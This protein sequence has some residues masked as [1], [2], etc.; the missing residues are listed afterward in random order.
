MLG[1]TLWHTA[2]GRHKR[3][4]F[5]DLV[6]VL[7]YTRFLCWKLC[8]GWNANY[9]PSERITSAHCQAKNRVA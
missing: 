2:A 8:C 5:V 4:R 9:V 1:A 7:F 3:S 6:M